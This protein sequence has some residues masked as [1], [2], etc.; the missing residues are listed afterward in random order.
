MLR[1]LVA[2]LLMLC[3]SW[4]ALA[5]SGA[6]VAMADAQERAHALLHFKG[7][8]H[9]HGHG[10]GHDRE[11]GGL[12]ATHDHP[13]NPQHAVP[14]QD[15][16]LDDSP[17]SLVHVVH[18]ASQFSP[19]LVGTLPGTPGLRQPSPPAHWAASLQPPPPPEALER[20][21]RLTA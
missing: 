20:P 19:A 15:L 7:V 14:A 1:R 13:G 3:L 12:D 18:D 11:P 21:P 16:H 9:H 17:A 10:H 2:T 6:G 4:Q 5:A 8:A